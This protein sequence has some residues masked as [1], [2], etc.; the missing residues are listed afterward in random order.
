[1]SLVT[2]STIQNAVV[3]LWHSPA[4]LSRPLKLERRLI[5]GRW[6]GIAV[7]AVALALNIT[8]MERTIAAYGVLGVASVYNLVLLRVLRSAPLR[9]V[10]GLP[11]IADGLL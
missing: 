4:D 9:L 1:M 3:S 5:L 7:F 2:L 6:L 8:S 10:V 11:T